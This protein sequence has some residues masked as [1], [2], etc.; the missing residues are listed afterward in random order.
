MQD[1]LDV[2]ERFKV[3]LI[4]HLRV[5]IGEDPKHLVS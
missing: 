3:L 4:Q 1:W 2:I 5:S